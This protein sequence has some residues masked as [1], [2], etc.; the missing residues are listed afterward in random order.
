MDFSTNMQLDTHSY[1]KLHPFSLDN[2]A[3]LAQTLANVNHLCV[4][5]C[6]RAAFYRLGGNYNAR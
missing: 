3:T 6:E 4:F 2:I 5:L 1:I